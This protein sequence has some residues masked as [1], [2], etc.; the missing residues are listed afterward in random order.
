[1]KQESPAQQAAP[2]GLGIG[3]MALAGWA[4]KFPAASP[5]R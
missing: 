5:R 3:G 4:G 1:M 2:H